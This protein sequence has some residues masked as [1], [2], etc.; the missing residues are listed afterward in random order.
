VTLTGYLSVRRL[1]RRP[2][3]GPAAAGVGLLAGWLILAALRRR[4]W[5]EPL[6]EPLPESL[7]VPGMR[8]SPERLAVNM[9]AGDS[10]L[11]A[12]ADGEE[13]WW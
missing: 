11:L 5:P 6:P 2:L 13:A 8:W 12:V 7:P 1:V 10:D 3:A 4:P 9:L